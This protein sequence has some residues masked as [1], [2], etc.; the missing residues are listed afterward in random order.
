VIRY[1]SFLNCDP[2]SLL[3]I[4]REQPAVRSLMQPISNLLLEMFVLSKPYFDRDGLIV[5]V[6]D[7]QIV[8]FVHAGFGPNAERNE[9]SKQTG[10]ICVL[11]ARP[12]PERPAILRGLLAQAEEYLQQHGAAEIR[13]GGIFPSSPFYLGLSGGSDLPGISSTDDEM[14]QLYREHGYS[15]Q[16]RCVAFERGLHRYRPPVDRRLLQHRRRYRLIPQVN[17]PDAR[18]WDAC[19]FGPADRIRFLLA[20]K[21]SNVVAGRITFWDMGPLSTRAQTS[22]MGMLDL[23]IAPEERRQGLGTFLVC[24]AL[25]HL[26]NSGVYRVETQTMSDNEAAQRLLQKLGFASIR[27]GIFYAKSHA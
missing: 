15:E 13:V 26:N 11:M 22:G 16:S 10:I 24:E 14:G 4:W 8:G 19:V 18:W 5:A 7:G 3:R 27:E 20:P 1:R 17:P 25:K 2:P 9:M 21:D 12:H 23:E 6:E